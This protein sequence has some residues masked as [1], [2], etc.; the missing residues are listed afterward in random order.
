MKKSLLVFIAAIWVAQ[1]FA[2]AD[3]EAEKKGM[4]ESKPVLTAVK[5]NPATP[6]KNQ[7]A[8]GT[9][10]SFSTTSL[11]ESQALK[12]NLGEFDLSE[13]FTVRNIYIEKAKNYVLRQ[14]FAR[15]S[16]GGLGHDQINAIAKYGAMP[17][18][19]YSGLTGGKRSHDH[20]RLVSNLKNY[21]D[22]VIKTVP[23]KGDWLAGYT[24]ILDEALGKPPA[25]FNFRGQKYDPQSFA[26][27]VLKF[28]ADDYVAFTSFTHHPYYRSFI[29][30]VP[31]NFSNGAYF[32][33]PINE[34]MQLTKET[35][36]KG[37]T[38]MWDAD[39]SNP[40]FAQ[41]QGIA[42]LYDTSIIAFK[43]MNLR[44]LR[45]EAERRQQDTKTDF[46]ISN[47]EAN[48]P[49]QSGGSQPVASTREEILWDAEL[50]Q[51]LF[52]SLVTQDDHLMHITG[53][54]KAPGGKD[55]FIVK[56]SWGN[57]GPEGG[58]IH[59]SESYFGINTISIIVP[60]AA[61]SKQLLE[62]LKIN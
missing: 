47:A 50:R 23:V 44:R 61:I 29:L 45:E 17:E 16:E 51:T 12:N 34:M 43:K 52:E 49:K 10:W 8:T 40:G 58:Y 15:F 24:K 31:D 19:V 18:S 30:E 7:A 3:V 46:E 22:S 9:C 38:V 48:K 60:K 20:Q 32:N 33:L 21:L 41:G 26:K 14:G 13:M 53:I 5:K 6:V 27:D 36:N 28:N 54:G 59:V 2:Q 39:V 42:A 37:Y 4:G 1:S 35:L 56:N 57:V 55:Y 25:E 62:K 11:V